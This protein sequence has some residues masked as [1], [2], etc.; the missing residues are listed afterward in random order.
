[1]S[2][3]ALIERQTTETNIRLK[4]ALDGS[5]T[6]QG[7]SGIPFFDHLLAQMARH[8]LLDLKVW[9]EGDLEVDNHHTVED[10]GI[11]LG[12]A[13]KK[14]LGDKKGISRYGSALV[15][16]DEALVLVA[17]DFSGRPYLAWG[18]ELPPGRIGSLETELVEEFLRA[19]VNNSG[20]TLHVRQL[21]GHNAHH[22]AEALF[23]ALGRAIRQAVT[24]DPREQGI[25]STKGIL[26]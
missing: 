21:A 25:P 3:E 1:M 13:V 12:Q 20:L 17:L 19:M 14:A 15:P 11:C 16:M 18:L 2:R 8:G 26:S 24:L 9:A 5:G 22:L 6:W 10:I 7:S 23:K 4:V